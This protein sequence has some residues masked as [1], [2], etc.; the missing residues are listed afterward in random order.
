MKKTLLTLLIVCAVI[1][2]A[3]LTGCQRLAQSPSQSTQ[4]VG[5]WTL[6][7]AIGS[8][9]ANGVTHKD[10][11]TFTSADY[12][13]YKADGTLAIVVTDSTYNGKW[14]IAN[15]KLMI[16]NTNYVDFPG[17]FDIS[18][19]TSNTLQLHYSV[20]TNSTSSDQWLNFTK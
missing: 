3:T 12:F 6:R 1:T 13:D 15:N 7:T 20:V 10:T 8:Y 18:T 11:T 9:T 16:S 14:Q 17:G 5:K 2:A 4:L 19:L